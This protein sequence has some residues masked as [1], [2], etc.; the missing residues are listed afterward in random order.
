[1]L[2]LHGNGGSAADLDQVSGLSELAD[3]RGFLAVYPQGLSVGAGPGGRRRL[4]R[5]RWGHR[6]DRL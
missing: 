1:V 4:L 5:R 6:P 3:R 2:L